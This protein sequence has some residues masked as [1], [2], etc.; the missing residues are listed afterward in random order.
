[1]T[2]NQNLLEN[3]IAYLAVCGQLDV[4]S[5]GMWV[6]FLKAKSVAEVLK[7]FKEFHVMVEQ[8]SDI[9]IKALRSDN[10]KE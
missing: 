3:I 10:R 1:M 9:N 2:R 4:S 5:L 6:Y 7:V 8:Q